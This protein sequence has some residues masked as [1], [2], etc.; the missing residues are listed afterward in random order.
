M[1]TEIC[2]LEAMRIEG[3]YEPI[4]SDEFTHLRKNIEAKINKA[5]IN[6]GL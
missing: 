1:L 6:E 5:A 3:Y 2:E 4:F